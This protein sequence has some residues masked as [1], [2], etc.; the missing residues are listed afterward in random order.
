MSGSRN[1]GKTTVRP[2]V[3]DDAAA[4]EKILDQAFS[5]R[6]WTSTQAIHESA[7]EFALRSFLVRASFAY[8]AET[9]GQVIGLLIG[10]IHSHRKLPIS[11]RAPHRLVTTTAKIAVRAGRQLPT[12]WQHLQIDRVYRFYESFGMKRVA[13]AMVHFTLKG[14]VHD[15]ELYLYTANRFELIDKWPLVDRVTLD[16]PLGI[17]NPAELRRHVFGEVLQDA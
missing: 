3:S 15:R 13:A 12:L 7:T 16:E 1:P 4:V 2:Y 10:C 11:L 14:R 6:A 17:R 9:D 8:V 5:I